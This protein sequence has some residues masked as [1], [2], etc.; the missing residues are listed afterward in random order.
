MIPGTLPIGHLGAAPGSLLLEYRAYA[1]QVDSASTTI[2]APADIQAGDL[3]LSLSHSMEY[4]TTPPAAAYATGFTGLFTCS[5]YTAYGKGSYYAC[6]I[7]VGYKIADG[8]EASASIGGWMTGSLQCN[9]Q[10]GVYR[11]VA[12]VISNVTDNIVDYGFNKGDINAFP[13]GKADNENSIMISIDSMLL[14]NGMDAALYYYGTS[15]PVTETYSGAW[16]GSGYLRGTSIVG[17]LNV[18]V[19]YYEYDN[20]QAVTCCHGYILVS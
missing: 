12:G 4:G 11:P 3:I 19:R 17:P 18:D 10:L 8:S 9:K 1:N 15:T 7:C 2:T 16:D 20:D 14:A 5:Q 6:R 13:S